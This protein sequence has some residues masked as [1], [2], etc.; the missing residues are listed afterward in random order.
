MAAW[1]A[2][3]ILL[4]TR[5]VFADEADFARPRD[6]EAPLVVAHSEVFY[7]YQF[8]DSDG[9]LKGFA[10]D[11]TL[12]VTKAVNLH[13]Q[14]LVVTNSEMAPA[15]RD[16]RVDLLHFFSETPDRHAQFEFSV[17]IARFET[18]AV[19]RKDDSRIH[20]LSDL[21]GRRVGVGQEGTVGW[22]YLHNEQPRAEPVITETSEQFLRMVSSGAIDAAVMSRLTAVSMI[23]RFGL[24]NLTVL[25]EHIPGDK[26]DVRYCYTVRKGDSLLLARLNEG[27]AI[28]HRTGEFDEI[29]RRWFGRYE[30]RT[31]RRE[32][33]VTYAATALGLAC[34]AITWG[35]LRQRALR[36]R[37]ARQAAELAEQ[38]SLLAALHEKHPLAT[39]ILEI[40]V[41]GPAILVSANTEALRL[42]AIDATVALPLPL[43]AVPLAPELHTYLEDAVKHWR[44]GAHARQWE[45]RLPA[46]QQ[47]LET[48]LVPLGHDER[49]RQRLCV[50]SNDVTRRRLMDQEVAQSRRLRALGELVGGIAHEFNNL[51]TPIILTTSQARADRTLRQEVLSD[52]AIVEGA[53]RR[54]A[55]LTQ[56]LLTFG[57]KADDS[58]QPVRLSD[59]VESCFALLRPT[60]DRRIEWSVRSGGQLP[61]LQFNPTDLNQIVFNLVIN[62]RDT[63]MEKLGRS[64]PDGWTPRLVVSIA[65]LEAGTL[66]TPPI[67][68]RA[69]AAWQRV[70][71]EDNGQGIPPDIIDRIFEPFFTTK[72][73]GHGTGLGLATVWHLVT[74][75]GGEV[76][77]ESVPGAGTQFHVTL[78]R[79]HQ[80][81]GVAPKAAAAPPPTPTG[82][83]CRVLLVE[84]EAL[85][86]S[87]AATLLQRSGHAVTHRPNGADAWALLLADPVA[88]DLLLVDVNMPRMSGIDLIRHVRE[89]RYHGAIVVMSGRITDQERR[90]LEQLHVEDIL[91]K[92]F[93]GAELIETVRKAQLRARSIAA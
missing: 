34:L 55:E 21:N 6:F 87:T 70:T 78:P 82:G 18:V 88:F 77:V 45:S 72:D 83:G 53:A 5:S 12:A 69:L 24:K 27:L 81:A 16:G 71:V 8:R 40:P 61:P 37:I 7:P 90:A 44:D 38:R 19:V 41:E 3:A 50:L 20:K 4:A 13:V 63:L 93:G 57:R 17:P 1:S 56:R 32:E 92:P 84:D 30:A 64:P 29:Y 42:F 66:P 39:L 36:R 14:W 23:D 73:V 75:A 76:A 58:A 80:P 35:F 86:A 28:V 59:A 15:L 9:R 51:L 31:F 25:D 54:A 60:V 48:A 11:L 91:A 89:T 52:F 74:E 62:A 49:G 2:A 22:N 43:A 26:Y 79:W 68:P 65:E 47:L 10:H 33:V 67:G 46:T 85:V